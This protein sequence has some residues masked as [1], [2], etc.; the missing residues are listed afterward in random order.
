MG[1]MGVYAKKMIGNGRDGREGAVDG[2]SP[3]GRRPIVRGRV[4]Q[5]W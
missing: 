5:W 1:R 4:R 3:S 2:T